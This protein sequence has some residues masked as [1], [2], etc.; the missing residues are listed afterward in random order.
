MGQNTA[1]GVGGTFSVSTCPLTGLASAAADL[2]YIGIPAASVVAYFF[3]VLI[4]RYTKPDAYRSLMLAFKL[5]ILA[6]GVLVSGF[7]LLHLH[8]AMWLL[9]AVRLFIGLIVY[10]FYG[11]KHTLVNPDHPLDD[12]R[13]VLPYATVNFRVV[14][15]ARG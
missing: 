6:F 12:K 3:V 10:F 2:A 11:C 8:R 14:D 1:F 9:F 7:L 13:V 5:V 4:C 15:R